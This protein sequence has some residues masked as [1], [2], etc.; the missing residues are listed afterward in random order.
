MAASLPVDFQRLLHS[1][2]SL[3]KRQLLKILVDGINLLC[4]NLFDRKCFEGYF[5]PDFRAQRHSRNISSQLQIFSY[6]NS[7][8][9]WREYE[10]RERIIL[11]I[12][13][14]CD[15]IVVCCIS[16]QLTIF[17]RQAPM[18]SHQLTSF[19]AILAIQLTRSS[20]SP[21]VNFK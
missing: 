19:I 20:I 16:A 11:D 14:P 18:I 4:W 6:T 1:Y 13:D 9:R 12:V 3:T 8:E 5:F 15:H 7:C 10:R 2:Q 21:L 17:A